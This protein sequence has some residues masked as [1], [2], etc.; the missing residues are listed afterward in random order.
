MKE[1]IKREIVKFHEK[2][3][4]K[5]FDRE[6]KV[7]SLRGKATSIIGPRRAGK[8]FYLYS[9]V[10]KNEINKFIYL[11]FESPLL[12]NFSLSDFPK[13]IDAYFELYPENLHSEVTLLLDEIQNVNGW[14]R[15]VRY[16]LSEGFKVY[17]TGSSSKLLAKEIATSLRGRA[18][19][20]VLLTLSF[21][22]FLKF[23]GIKVNE[24]SFY[25]KEKYKLLKLFKE[26]LTFGGY[27]EVVLFNEK[28]RILKEYFDTIV[29]KDVVERYKIRNFSFL[30]SLI[31]FL[32]SAYSKYI[33]YSSI[34]KSFK[35]TFKITKRTVINYLK[36]L[37]DSF[38]LMQLRKFSFSKKE[39]ERSPR[40]V[41]FVD[42]GYSI[43]SNFDE[44]RNFENLVFLE[45]LRRKYYDDPLIDVYYIKGDKGEIDFVIFRKGR[46]IELIQ[47]CYDLLK[48]D[49]EQFNR[50][51]NP[52]VHYSSL[53]KCNSLKIITLDQEEE[54]QVRN[55]KIKVLPF[56]RFFI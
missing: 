45:L 3:F 41:Y 40:K 38:F 18:I 32:F 42:V 36:Y 53:F 29:M 55:K 9:L 25:G 35:G 6:L 34:Y 50:E 37:E 31:H 15:G 46:V 56:Y 11:D 30:T 8:T 47:V 33:T 12:Y 1:N 4:S 52:L 19:T 28:E 13:I 39:I 27:P 21:R 24:R 14:E 2:K 51:V 10:N 48:D 7:K 20:Y 23:K 44:S 16:L 54:I 43:F 5:I 26:Y 49:V 22:E 17:V